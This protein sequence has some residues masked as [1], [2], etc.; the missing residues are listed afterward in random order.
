LDDAVKVAAIDVMRRENA[1]GGGK[2]ILRFAGIWDAQ[3][4]QA[5]QQAINE[6]CERADLDEW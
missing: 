2:K 6:G 5:M 4:V 1:A 3:T